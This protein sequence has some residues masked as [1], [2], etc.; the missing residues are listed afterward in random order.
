MSK[1]CEWDVVKYS[2]KVSR[3]QVPTTPAEDSHLQEFHLAQVSTNGFSH[4][5]WHPALCF[6]VSAQN[7][8]LCLTGR[9]YRASFGVLRHCLYS[10][11]IKQI[12]TRRQCRLSSPNSSLW[13]EGPEARTNL[14][15][16]WACAGQCKGLS[17]SYLTRRC[18]RGKAEIIQTHVWALR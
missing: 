12:E 3:P 18:I 13:E 9:N 8:D 17:P 14:G 10:R 6:C 7:P 11:N 4:K 5:E 15:K 1:S 16:C 2:V